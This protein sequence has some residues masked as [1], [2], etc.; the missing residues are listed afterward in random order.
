MLV[1]RDAFARHELHRKTVNADHATCHFCGSVRFNRAGKPTLFKFYTERDGVYSS[2]VGPHYHTGLFC[3]KSCHD[4]F[5][6][7]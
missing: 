6:G 1:H 7:M 2:Y 5:H 3:S 4:A